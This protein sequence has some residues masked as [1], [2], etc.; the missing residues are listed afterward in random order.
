MLDEI[1]RMIELSKDTSGSDWIHNKNQIKLRIQ[2]FVASE[3]KNSN[4]KEEWYTTKC[5]LCNTEMKGFNQIH[6]HCKKCNSSF[7]N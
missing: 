6:Y 1:M 7:T 3:S 2:E 4:L 5:P